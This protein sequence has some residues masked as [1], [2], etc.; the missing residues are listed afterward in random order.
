[1]PYNSQYGEYEEYQGDR[2]DFRPLTMVTVTC[3]GCMN[4]TRTKKR[5]NIR[6]R[7]EGMGVRIMHCTDCHWQF[8]LRVAPNGGTKVW[9]MNEVGAFRQEIPYEKVWQE[10]TSK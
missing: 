5:I 7:R 6:T 4:K 2:R 9:T 1:M 3:K 8:E 10:R